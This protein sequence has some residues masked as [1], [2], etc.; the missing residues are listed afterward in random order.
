MLQTRR[1][2]SAL[3]TTRARNAARPKPNAEPDYPLAC[4]QRW[5]GIRQYALDPPSGNST[6]MARHGSLAT[7]LSMLLVAGAICEAQGALN[8]AADAISTSHVSTLR[9]LPCSGNRSTA[10][11]SSGTRWRS[12]Y[13]QAC[14][15]LTSLSC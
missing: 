9:Y 15:P 2:D 7:V 5:N 1:Q 10:R 11:E 14:R 4:L 6:F 12:L 8:G 13:W 3:Y